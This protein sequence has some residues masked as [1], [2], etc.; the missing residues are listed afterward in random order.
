MSDASSF[1][2]QLV[3][4]FISLS[5]GD[6]TA[7]LPRNGRRDTEDIIAY[8]VNV[9]AEELTELFAERDRSRA[10]LE[11]TVLELGEVLS[12][13]A[14]GDF[15]SQAT[16]RLDGSPSD[17]LA[18]QVN[19][20]GEEIGGLITDLRQQRE[21][22]E[23]EAHTRAT[24]RLSA[25]ST[26][27]AGVAHELNN[28]LT[29]TLMNVEHVQDALD[30]LD[31]EDDGGRFTA[32]VESLKEA[33]TGID[34]MAS[35]VDSLRELAP[36]ERPVNTVI[37]LCQTVDSSLRMV[38]NVVSHR[39]QLS[40]TH[41]D[42]LTVCADAARLGQVVINLV[43]NASL[44]FETASLASNC[45]SVATRLE[46]S[47]AVIE[48][49]DNG[50][51]IPAADLE[52][53][54]DAFF[55]TRRPNEGA[56]LG[57]SISRQT[58]REFGGDLQV[59]STH[60]RGSTFRAALPAVDIPTAQGE[61]QSPEVPVTGAKI[62]VI[63]DEP[64]ICRIITLVLAEHEVIAE[65]DGAAAMALVKQEAFDL[66]LC[67]M[68]MPNADGIDIYEAFCSGAANKDGRF[69]VITGGVFT[70]RAREFMDR[71]RVPF[72]TKPVRGKDLRRLVA[73]ILSPDETPK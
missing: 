18:F 68:M 27:A 53:I 42:E 21:Q 52:L 2:E 14:A 23:R 67:D 59:E 7:R 10:S 11:E 47:Q 13:H 69:V 37:D 28:P 38:Q 72:V 3:S 46:N 44:A 29:F 30:N 16:R 32:L 31:K 24:G 62:L 50:V 51:G 19:A 17:V 49:S 35:I 54:F 41:R 60:G 65:T 39:A 45:I 55:S 6:L 64:E 20:G 57:L 9:L 15:S 56:G 48:V 63:D 22:I 25:I 12:R 33:V 70:P 34:R 73:R 4:V 71:T 40:C 58:M 66:V 26:L 36:D 8:L 43:Q 1:H 61:E 5:Q